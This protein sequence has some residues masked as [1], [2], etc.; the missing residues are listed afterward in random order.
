M[1]S[2]KF[3][4]TFVEQPVIDLKTIKESEEVNENFNFKLKTKLQEPFNYTHYNEAILQSAEETA[5]MDN[6]VSQ[7][8]YHFSRYTLTPTLEARNSVLHS[9]RNDPGNANPS[10]LQRLEQLQHKID[11]T[12]YLAKTRWSCH[13]V[14][15]IHNMPFNPKKEWDNIKRLAGGEMSHHSA[16]TLI[17][18]RLPSVQ[19]A[20]N[21]EENV[22]VFTSYFKR[23]LNNHKPMDKEVINY[24][25]FVVLC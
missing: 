2:I 3:Q 25:L 13:L 14:M 7:G 11:V 9:I 5:M 20:E 16:P 23:V 17:Q 1:N 12:V 19:L 24:I 21:D 8:W 15:E 18:M 6:N 4:S 22:I 10:T